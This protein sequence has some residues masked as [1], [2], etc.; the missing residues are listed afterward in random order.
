MGAG[1]RI[2][3]FQSITFVANRRHSLRIGRPV[4]GVSECYRDLDE[5]AGAADAIACSGAAVLWDD[6]RARLQV[7]ICVCA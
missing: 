3:R 4:S 7:I 1:G 5:V 6:A 2:G